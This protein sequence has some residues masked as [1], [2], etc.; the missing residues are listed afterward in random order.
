MDGHV[1]RIYIRRMELHDALMLLDLRIRNR[2]FL[3]PYGYAIL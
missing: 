3:K 1:N 2:A